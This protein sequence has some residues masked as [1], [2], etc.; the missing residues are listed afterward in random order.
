M[1]WTE[2]NIY[3]SSAGIEPVTGCLLRLGITGFV[4]KDSGDFEELINDRTSSWDYIDDDLMGLKDCETCVTIYIA[5]NPEGR[6]LLSSVLS[7]IELLKARDESNEFGR[8]YT[9]LSNVREED[10]ADSW[11]QYFKPFEIGKNLVIKPSWEDYVNTG[12]R[13]I[14]EIDPGSSFGTGQHH[15]T[16]L[17]L[18][19]L[20]KNIS[21]GDRILDIG[22]GSGILS[23]AGMLLGGYSAAAVDTDRY[24]VDTAKENAAKNH[25]PPVHYNTYCGN[26][27]TEPELC[28]KIG[29][30]YNLITANIVADVIIEMSPLFKAFL[31]KDGIVIISGIIAERS[32]EVTDIMERNGYNRLEL[33]EQNGWVALSYSY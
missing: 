24:S 9:E 19:M 12:R 31:K 22:C 16:A 25:I 13:V 30:G 14:L 15:T 8:L 5:G 32:S 21:R 2:V 20:E 17:C 4:I 26:I 11:K 33:C 1:D 10:W 29:T 23:I 28:D 27:L 6:V 18:E 3:T 7:E